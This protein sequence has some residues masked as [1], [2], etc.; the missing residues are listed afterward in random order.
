[1]KKFFLFAALL[2]AAFTSPVWALSVVEFVAPESWN[3]DVKQ[4]T[5]S[6]FPN[7]S[8][9]SQEAAKTWDGPTGNL[10]YAID[11]TNISICQFMNGSFLA[12]YT[13]QFTRAQLYSDTSVG[14]K[15]Y[16]TTSG[17][18]GVGNTVVETKTVKRIVNGQLLVEK[19]GKLF[20]AQGTQVK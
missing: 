8:A 18:Q 13:I 12:A 19:N 9:V 4:V 6:D 15:W 1:M 14:T 7:F 16:Y 3:S 5:A 2:L 10:I 11:G 17:S 20:N